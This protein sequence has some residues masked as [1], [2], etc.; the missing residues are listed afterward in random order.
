MRCFLVIECCV[1]FR[2]D[3]RFI[4]HVLWLHGTAGR[5]SCV[6]HLTLASQQQISLW[7]SHVCEICL[8]LSRC[9]YLSSVFRTPPREA[10]CRRPVHECVCVCVCRNIASVMSWKVLNSVTKQYNLVL[11]KQRWCS[12]AGKVTAG[13]AGSNGNLPLGSWLP[14]AHWLPRDRDQLRLHTR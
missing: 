12:L 10:C 2:S 14:P 6:T 4:P 7:V 5:S 3:F 8:K 9:T 1:Q 13:L 11:T